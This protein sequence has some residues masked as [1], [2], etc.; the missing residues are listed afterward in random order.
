MKVL[1]INPPYP[2]RMVGFVV[3]G[4]KKKGVES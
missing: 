2:S 3:D 4:I 1:L